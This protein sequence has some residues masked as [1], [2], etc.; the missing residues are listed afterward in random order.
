MLTCHYA[1]SDML[2]N[3]K[4]TEKMQIVGETFYLRFC[5]LLNIIIYFEYMLKKIHPE[6]SKRRFLSLKTRFDQVVF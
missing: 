6:M 2:I 4:M 5:T 3:I 1:Y